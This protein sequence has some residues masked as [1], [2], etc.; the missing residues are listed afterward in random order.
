MD[1]HPIRRRPVKL[2]FA[3]I[4]KVRLIQSHFSIGPPR[5]SRCGT[6]GFLPNVSDKNTPVMGS[7]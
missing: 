2:G 1:V 6:P 3:E 7:F 5:N 4:H